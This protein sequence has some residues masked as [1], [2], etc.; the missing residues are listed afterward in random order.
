MKRMLVV[1]CLALPSLAGA[2]PADSTSGV[3][4]NSLRAGAWAV[5]FSTQGGFDYAGVFLKKHLAANHA[6]RMGAMVSLNTRSGDVSADTSSVSI[7][8][9]SLEADRF[10]ID[11]DVIAQ[12]Y[13]A[14]A[15]AAHVYYGVGPFFRYQEYRNEELDPE[16]SSRTWSRT[17]D[18]ESYSVGGIVML[19]AEWF[20]SEALSLAIEYP[21]SFGYTSTTRESSSGYVGYTIQH[22]LEESDGWFLDAGNGVRLALGIYF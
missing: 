11:V 9:G 14:V 16:T 21:I 17:F 10:S 15:A 6:V 18:E 7:G 8:K 4:A 19:G 12:R 2:A 22:E 20:P 5:Q 1:A 3:R 13:A